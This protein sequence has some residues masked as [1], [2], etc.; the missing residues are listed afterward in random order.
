[1]S[2]VDSK[3][4]ISATLFRNLI[5]R[6]Y[7]EDATWV[8]TTACSEA[9]HPA[10]IDKPYEQKRDWERKCVCGRNEFA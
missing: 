10:R 5:R 1:M 8:I 9:G 2:E 3:I 7:L 6:D 4:T